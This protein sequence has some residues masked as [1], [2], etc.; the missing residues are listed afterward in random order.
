MTEKDKKYEDIRKSVFKVV[1]KDMERGHVKENPQGDKWMDT[2]F[3]SREVFQGIKD[4]EKEDGEGTVTQYLKSEIL[5]KYGISVKT[6]A[7]AWKKGKRSTPRKHGKKKAGGEEESLES[8]LIDPEIRTFDQIKEKFH[9]HLKFKDDDFL[10]IFVA[11]CVS[12]FIPGDP[13]WIMMI[14]SPGSMKT[15]TLRSIG[16]RPNELCHPISDITPKTFISGLLDVNDLLPRLDGKIVTIKDFGT[17]LTKNKDTRN[18]ILGQMREIYDGTFHKATGSGKEVY[19]SS[20]MTMIIATTPIIDRYNTVQTLLGERYLRVRLMGK[21]TYKER[22]EIGRK[23]LNG[24]GKE[25]KMRTELKTYVQSFLKHIENS[26]IPTI[27]KEHIEPI[28]IMGNILAVLRT[29]I[30]K[31]RSGEVEYTPDPELPTR[32]VKQLGKLALSLALIDVREETNDN[33]LKYLWRV[34]LDCIDKTTM[35]VF[36]SLFGVRI[37]ENEKETLELGDDGIKT[38]IIAENCHIGTT[39]ARARLEDLMFLGFVVKD[40]SSSERHYSWKLNNENSMIKEFLNMQNRYRVYHKYHIYISND[41]NVSNSKEKGESIPLTPNMHVKKPQRE[42][43]QDLQKLIYDL[44]S[45]GKT[46][47]ID[48]IIKEA[49]NLG[50]NKEFVLSGID[51]LLKS[52]DI[53]KIDN[54][55]FKASKVDFTKEESTAEGSS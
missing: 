39:T 7:I 20:K 40:E 24:L 18:E 2:M 47:D 48:D 54:N 15:E 51:D 11:A 5:G 35:R 4:I 29:A 41:G 33:D 55:S 37:D 43:L 26:E 31:N 52:G 36:L 50:M 42:K 10:K 3:I 53:W 27:R 34:V 38:S 12:N 9:E 25:N 22:L 19:Y 17:I 28:V 45:D 30:I 14:A 21:D 23:A 1:D 8:L 44:S 32:C 49:K 6:I 13:L 16:E 46:A